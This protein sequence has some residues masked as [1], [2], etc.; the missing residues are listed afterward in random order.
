M[1]KGGPNMV[2]LSKFL[3]FLLRHG[4]EKEGLSMGTDGYAKVSDIL[5]LPQARKSHYTLANVLDVVND[6]DK[7]RF[8][9]KIVDN[10]HYIRANQGHSDTRVV[11]LELTPIKSL[12][13][14]PN[15]TAVHG[16]YF[17]AWRAIKKDG[18]RKMTRN[19]IHFALGEM[20][21]NEVIS[22]MRRSAEVMIFLDVAK[23][24]ADGIPL[25]LSANGVVLS[26]GAGAD[27]LIEPKYFLA[28]IRTSDRK[29]FDPAFPSE[30]PKV[31]PKPSAPLVG[32]TSR[33][34][35]ST[36][37]KKVSQ[38]GPAPPSNRKR[39]LE[40]RLAQIEELKM[41]SGQGI[42]LNSDQIKKI[43]TE[44]SIRAEIA[45]LTADD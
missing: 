37:E 18:L 21:A 19:H 35:G 6:N 36:M 8:A 45:S 24:L 16:T 5:A 32:D 28:V 17:D 15:G 33:S 23:A 1:E 44:A 41:K 22:G 40:R 2:T 13:Q 34:S 3:S 31:P 14:L 4:A 12:D 10:I 43:A 20:G 27:G 38:Q 29:P 30:P 11:D 26:P 7:K 25:L 9:I 39:N 42:V